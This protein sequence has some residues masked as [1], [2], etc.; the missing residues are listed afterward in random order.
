MHYG[1]EDIAAETLTNLS[2][3]FIRKHQDKPFFLYLA[4]FDVHAPINA[5]EEITKIYEAKYKSHPE[6]YPENFDPTYGGDDSCS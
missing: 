5:K 6:K 3:D 4:H 2:I 1:D